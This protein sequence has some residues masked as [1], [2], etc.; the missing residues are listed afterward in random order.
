[1]ESFRST[2]KVSTVG[3]IVQYFGMRVEDWI[4]EANRALSNGCSI[5]VKLV[6]SLASN[7]LAADSVF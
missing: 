5:L 3:D 6:S 2:A 4:Q 1:M 7:S